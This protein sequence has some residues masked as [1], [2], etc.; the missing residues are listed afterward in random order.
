MTTTT[1]HRDTEE[2]TKAATYA[3]NK[4]EMQVAVGKQQAATMVAHIRSHMPKDRLWEGEKIFFELGDG[5]QLMMGK[6]G[7]QKGQFNPM[8]LHRNALMQVAKVTHIPMTL[9]NYLLDPGAAGD[10]EGGPEWSAKKKAVL[11]GLVRDMF[12]APDIQKKA[13]LLRATGSD[14]KLEVRAFL[15]DMFRPL[16]SDQILESFITVCNEAGAAPIE[17]KFDDIRFS[18]KAIYPEVI[19]PLK[20]E[21]MVRGMALRHSDFGVG[22]LT[23]RDFVERLICTNLAIGDSALREVHLGNRLPKGVPLS[24]QTYQLDSQTTASAVADITRQLIGKEAVDAT[25]KMIR[26]AA[27]TKLD[28][29]QIRSKLGKVLLKP[30]LERAKDMW[31]APRDPERLPEGKNLYAASNIVSWLAKDVAQLE[32]QLVL[33]R[34]A[35]LMLKGQAISAEEMADA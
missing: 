9:L 7:A 21:P 11:F 13:W 5:N 4:M 22:A 30:E 19:E 28:W 29:E 31:E 12:A 24:P 16:N 33:Q 6:K 23:I 32:R 2:W 20:N 34:A 3:R 15:S 18:L 10:K 25:V 8:P 14:D 35:G 17:A 27:G 26:D 1:D